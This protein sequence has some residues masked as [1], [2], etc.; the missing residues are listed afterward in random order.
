MGDSDDWKSEMAS[1]CFE[2]IDT[3]D[4]IENFQFL[5]TC[6]SLKNSDVTQDRS[7]R[8]STNLRDCSSE[9]E[10]PIYPM[11][12]KDLTEDNGDPECVP[13]DSKIK[14]PWDCRDNIMFY[15][16]AGYIVGI[17]IVQIWYYRNPQK[18]CKDLNVKWLFI[19]IIG[20]GLLLMALRRQGRWVAPNTFSIFVKISFLQG[21]S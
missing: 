7:E 2:E 21:A 12:S 5:D 18:A 11:E 14:A 17:L 3:D 13:E 19:V 4:L 16:I 1:S 10:P 8:Y 6:R 15:V 20:L 9:G